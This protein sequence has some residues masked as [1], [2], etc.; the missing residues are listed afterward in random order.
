LVSFL[1]HHLFQDWRHGVYHLAQQFLDYEPGI[2][3]TQFQMQAGST[4]VNSIRVYNPV[5]NS[6]KHDPEGEFIKQW[7]PE[8][9]KLPLHLRHEPW[10]ITSMEELMYEFELGVDYPKPIVQL[11][12]TRA[13]TEQLWKLRKTEEA[14]A[15]G[16]KILK[17]FVR[18]KV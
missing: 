6:L 14:K 16:Q 9:S 13:K 10:K 7:C 5:S 17:R 1:T 12:D 8:L 18:P 11:A 2:H 15:E 4:G 3:Y